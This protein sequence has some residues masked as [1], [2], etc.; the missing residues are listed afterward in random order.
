VLKIEGRKRKRVSP[1]EI[2]CRQGQ[3]KGDTL[4]SE[5]K[6]ALSSP[7]GQ[8]WQQLQGMVLE[9]VRKK[10]EEL[11]E[12]ERESRLGRA[13]QGRG[14][15]VAPLGPPGVQAAAC[16]LRTNRG[17]ASAAPAGRGKEPGSGFAEL[18][19]GRESAGGRLLPQLAAL[20]RPLPRLRESVT[21][22]AR[23]RPLSARSRA[24]L[25]GDALP[26]F[27]AIC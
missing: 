11:A 13:R 7:V 17:S 21:R 24:G 8:A 4:M 25:T 27:N 6:V 1:V 12:A 22:R 20:P 9:E 23:P 14:Q 26:N 15:R 3:E 19:A 16:A 5:Q 10:V 2:A 18:G